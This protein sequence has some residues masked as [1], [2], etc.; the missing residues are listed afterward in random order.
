MAMGAAPVSGHGG[1][2][3]IATVSTDIRVEGWKMSRRATLAETTDASRS[4][5]EHRTKVKKGATLTATIL[6]S[7]DIAPEDASLDAGDTF[8]ATLKLGDSTKRY[9]SVEFICESCD[10]TGCDQNGVVRAEI[11]AHSNGAVPDPTAI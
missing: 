1:Q 10:V 9:A 6:W 8:T 2:I 5:W 11:T 4:G 7:S 3:T